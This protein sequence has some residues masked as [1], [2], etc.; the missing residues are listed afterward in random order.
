MNNNQ[1][2][3]TKEGYIRAISGMLMQI[4]DIKFLKRIYNLT[5]Y[6]YKK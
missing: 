5:F 6:L 2:T 4:A 1:E 3:I